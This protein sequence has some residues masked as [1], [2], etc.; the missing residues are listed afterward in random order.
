M[1]GNVKEPTFAWL[2]TK[3][4]KLRIPLFLENTSFDVNVKGQPA[5]WS[6]SGVI[7]SKRVCFLKMKWKM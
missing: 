2:M 3:D 6:V 1:T 5:V 7:S 4:V